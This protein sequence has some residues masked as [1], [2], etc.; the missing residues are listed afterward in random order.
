M[1][2]DRSGVGTLGGSLQ[3]LRASGLDSAAAEWAK[4]SSSSKSSSQQQRE[5][6]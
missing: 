1:E 6:D 4:A 3:G 2:P 5:L